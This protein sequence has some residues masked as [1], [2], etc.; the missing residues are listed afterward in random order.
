MIGLDRGRLGLVDLRMTGGAGK[1]L[2]L[3]A[4]APGVQQPLRR[5]A[6]LGA[7]V[8]GGAGAACLVAAPGERRTPGMRRAF[9]G[10]ETGG[11]PSRAHVLLELAI[12]CA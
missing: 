5:L 11:R 10:H 7:G 12:R 3:E 9:G 4:A 8:A 6:A 1:G 2:L